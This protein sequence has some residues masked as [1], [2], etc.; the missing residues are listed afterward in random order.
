[1][2]I[3]CFSSTSNTYFS[4]EN[5]PAYK[6]SGLWSNDFYALT[7][8]EVDKYYMKTPPKGMYLGSSNGRIAWVCIPPPTQDDLISAANQEKKKR[9]N[10]ANEHMNSRRWPGKAALGRLTGDELAQ[11]NLW[12]DYL[13]ALKAVDTSVAQNIACPIRK[14]IH[15]K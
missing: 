9:I 7:D 14:A 15:I 1:M 6:A 12:L 2:S 11:Y 8:E 10:Q 3:I 4:E 5:I 13:D